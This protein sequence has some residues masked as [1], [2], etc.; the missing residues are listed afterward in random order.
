MALT[1]AHN[2]MIESAPVNIV[3]FG[4][5]PTGATDSASAIQTALDTNKNVFVPVGNFKIGS[6]L[7]FTRTNQVFFGESGNA[8]NAVTTTSPA[9]AV[10]V[11]QIFTES[12]IL[13]FSFNDKQGV[14]IKDVVFNGTG[15]AT[16]GVDC[17]GSGAP[18]T[19][20]F[21]VVLQNVGFKA[22]NGIALDTAELVDANFYN[23]NISGYDDASVIK[24][25]RG[26]NCG[27]TNNNFYGG[28]IEGCIYGAYILGSI[29]SFFGCTIANQ[30]GT[31]VHIGGNIAQL[32]FNGCYIENGVMMYSA[33]SYVYGCV[34]F[35]NCF[36][37]TSNTSTL[38][39][40]TNA[41]SGTQVN[42]SGGRITETAG[43]STIFVPSGVAFNG[44][45]IGQTTPTMTGT[46][47]IQIFSNTSN[48][49]ADA[50]FPEHVRVNGT[51][52]RLLSGS[53]TPETAVTAPIG[54]VFMRTDGSTG[55][56]FYAKESG[57]G[58]TGWVAK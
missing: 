10:G 15:V 44:I 58:N 18:P 39:D 25:T 17:T 54:S 47:R 27:A 29:N 41:A 11:S 45:N 1:K 19:I 57:T 7:Q 9:S 3:D 34:D 20:A 48:T 36:L 38:L 51:A 33:S 21:G 8:V 43:S 2:R 30:G 23:I 55:T 26:I 56:S 4:A 49:T 35:S 24:T 22:I 13:M 42:I 31:N 28:R 46:G 40:L 50:V 5:D 12:A 37:H 16:G 53:G 14:Q 52:A 32:S 6:T